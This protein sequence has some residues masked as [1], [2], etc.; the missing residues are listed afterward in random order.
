MQAHGEIVDLETA[1]ERRGEPDADKLFV[2]T[3]DDGFEDVYHNAF[4]LLKE[5]GA[6]VHAVPD[7]QPDRDG[8]A[9]RSPVSRSQAADLGSGHRDGRHRA[10]HG[11][12]PH[13]H[14]R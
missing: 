13:A 9:T 8:R 5:R 14:P 2:L 3:F 12:G 11:G 10:G 1:I 4:P 7:D 6:A